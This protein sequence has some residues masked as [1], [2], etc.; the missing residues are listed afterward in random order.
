LSIAEQVIKVLSLQ[1]TTAVAEV[2][3]TIW[4]NE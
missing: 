4:C 2:I 1:C 3:V